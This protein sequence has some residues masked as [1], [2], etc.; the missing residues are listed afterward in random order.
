MKWNV[1]HNSL[2]CYPVFPD[3][4]IEETGYL[5]PSHFE[6]LYYQ[7][8]HCDAVVGMTT[9]SVS[10]YIPISILEQKMNWLI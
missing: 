8:Y 1:I 5:R 4:D 2:I 9:G 6:L 10:T 7:N 3:I